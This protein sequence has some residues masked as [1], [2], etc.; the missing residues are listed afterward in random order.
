MMPN[1]PSDCY[2]IRAKSS[3]GSLIELVGKILTKRLKVRTHDSNALF[4]KVM[5]SNQLH[6]KALHILE[7][8]LFSL[9]SDKSS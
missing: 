4:G 8:L 3:Y 2:R 5:L 1:N 9:L 7:S 6:Q